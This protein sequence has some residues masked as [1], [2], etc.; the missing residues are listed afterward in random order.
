VRWALALLLVGCGSNGAG[1]PDSAV[2]GAG[3][4]GGDPQPDTGAQ[5]DTVAQVDTGPS[6]D[7]PAPLPGTSVDDCFVGLRALKGAFQDA[8]RASADGRYRM[9]LALETADRGGTSGTFAWA[10]VRVALQTPE[11]SLCLSDE[12]SLAG[13]GVYMGSHHNCMD[14]L[15]VGYG[16]TKYVVL[17]PDS[18]VDYVDKTKWRREASLGITRE[19]VVFPP[20]TLQTVS[21]N[22]SSRSDG[23]CTSGGP[24]Q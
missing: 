12:A 13:A 23:A 17:R 19:D 2:G 8:T 10:P 20:V 4:A 15:T 3:G 6:P 9:R 11:G 24:C 1:A 7:A 21:C 5:P 14:R 22:K 16:A 18:A